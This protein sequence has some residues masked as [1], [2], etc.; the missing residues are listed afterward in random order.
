MMNFEVLRQVRDLLLRTALVTLILAWIV[1]GLT[2]GLWDVWAGT[3]SQLFRTPV[4]ELGPVIVNFFSF[5]KF[6]MIFVLLAPAL[7]L[8]WEIKKREKQGAS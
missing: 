6:Y 7:G 4:A 3:T 1:A 2:F 8:H 5:I